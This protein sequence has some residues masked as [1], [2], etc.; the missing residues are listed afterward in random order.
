VTI[1]RRAA[2]NAPSRRSQF[3]DIKGV[4]DATECAQQR[5]LSRWYC[6]ARLGDL[7]RGNFTIA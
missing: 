5:V 3:I 7:L 4:K 2:R 1:L 6:G